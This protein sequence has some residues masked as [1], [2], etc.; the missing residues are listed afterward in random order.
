M[1]DRVRGS[2]SNANAMANVSLDKDMFFRRMKRMYAAWKVSTL[3]DRN[4]HVLRFFDNPD[5]K[6]RFFSIFHNPFV[7]STIRMEKSAPMIVSVK[8]T[9]WSRL[10]APTRISFTASPRRCR[11]V[12]F[13][14]F[15]SLLFSKFYNTYCERF[16]GRMQYFDSST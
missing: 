10:S 11:Y 4:A 8:W 3:E 1:R 6:L 13:K 16:L 15:K 14:I 2:K 7:F 9:V 5:K 12:R